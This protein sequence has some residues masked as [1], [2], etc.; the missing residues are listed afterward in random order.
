WR[1][2]KG[3]SIE[4]VNP[5]FPY[6]LHPTML[7]TDKVFWWKRHVRNHLPRCQAVNPITHCHA[8][9]GSLD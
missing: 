4:A 3:L 1:E 2:R 6:T 5:D 9:L 7:L 8:K